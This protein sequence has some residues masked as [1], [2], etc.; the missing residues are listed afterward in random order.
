MVPTLP[1]WTIFYT[2]PYV[3]LSDGALYQVKQF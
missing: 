3:E 2:I 1:L